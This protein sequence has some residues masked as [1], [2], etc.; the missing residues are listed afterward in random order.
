MYLGNEF[1]GQVEN[2]KKRCSE[3]NKVEWYD[4]FIRKIMK[5]KTQTHKSKKHSLLI[6]F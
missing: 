6:N 5:K 4:I 3:K 2:E 1:N